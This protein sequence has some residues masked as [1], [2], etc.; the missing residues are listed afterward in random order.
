MA[1][2]SVKQVISRSTYTDIV[3]RA[4]KKSWTVLL[5]WCSVREL[6]LPLIPRTSGKDLAGAPCRGS[7][8]C[9]G[10]VVPARNRQEAGIDSAGSDGESNTGPAHTG[11]A[12]QAPAPARHLLRLILTHPLGLSSGISPLGS[13]SALCRLSE[14]CVLSPNK[15]KCPKFGNKA[16]KVGLPA[17]AMLG[18]GL[19]SP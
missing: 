14:A 17:V 19:K 11:K 6:S 1:E 18:H 9:K 5:P 8:M 15:R 4:E 7:S 10:P 2:K 13:L 3:T 16:K 12:E